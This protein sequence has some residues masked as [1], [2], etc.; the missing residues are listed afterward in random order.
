MKSVIL[1]GPSRAGKSILSRRLNDS[2]RLCP[3][4]IDMTVV[5]L[6]AA[7]P[8][9]E[10]NWE[11]DEAS[12]ARLAPF[13]KVLICKMALRSG[14]AYVFEGN[15]LTPQLLVNLGSDYPILEGC[16]P[17]F[18][19]SICTDRQARLRS[20]RDYAQSN[21]CYT[22]SM[23]DTDVLTLIDNLTAES[24]RIQQRCQRLEFAYFDTASDFDAGL[25]AA[26]RY[27]ES[28]VY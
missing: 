12:L 21:P 26:R 4:P 27:V 5:S 17:V 1:G 25:E 9:L 6:M 20:L 13:L 3:M 24:K 16:V 14:S 18:L 23:S 8:E 28:R 10:I 22:K 2:L 7:F 19:G 11:N 15:H